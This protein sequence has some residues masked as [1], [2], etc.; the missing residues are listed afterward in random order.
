MEDKKESVLILQ[1]CD[2]YQGNMLILNNVN[3]TI[4]HGEFVYLIGKTGS[5][6]SSLLKTIYG[7]LPLKRGNASVVGF[8]L[9]KTKPAGMYKLRRNLGMVFQDFLLLNDRSISNNLS[10]SLRAMGW[11]DKLQINNRIEEV[12]DSVGLKYIGHKYPHELSGGEQQRV[13]IARAILNKPRLLIADEP[14][15]NLDPDTADDI[16]RLI[17]KVSEEVGTS[18]LFATHDYRII[19][20]FPAKVIRCE[21]HTIKDDPDQANLYQLN[22]DVRVQDSST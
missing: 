9:L 14:T 3:L 15:G 13:A 19:N 21:Q 6:K 16:M 4:E 10:F 5:G 7:T 22:S 20:K 1:D 17:L 18:V 11:R 8:D 12:L 2:I